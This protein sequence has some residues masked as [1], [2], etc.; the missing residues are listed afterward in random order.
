MGEASVNSLSERSDLKVF[1]LHR[2]I[3]SSAARINFLL[4]LLRSRRVREVSDEKTGKRFL[5]YFF[6]FSSLLVYLRFRLSLKR[7]RRMVI[8]LGLHSASV[9]VMVSLSVRIR[10]A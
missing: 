1:T 2:I 3:D 5:F 4:C 6:Q 10:A 9:T 8:S 7:A